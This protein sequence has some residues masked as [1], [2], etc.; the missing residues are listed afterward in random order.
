[1]YRVTSQKTEALTTLR[2]K[3][4]VFVNSVCQITLTLFLLLFISGSM[5]LKLN[6]DFRAEL[7]NLN[8]CCIDLYYC[9]MMIIIVVLVCVELCQIDLKFVHRR[10]VCKS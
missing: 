2:R 1:M 6:K 8:S 7:R 10:H 9:I 5:S 4:E 3:P